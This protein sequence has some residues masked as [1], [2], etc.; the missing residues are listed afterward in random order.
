MVWNMLSEEI[1]ITGYI[2]LPHYICYHMLQVPTDRNLQ[3]MSTGTLR[4]ACSLCCFFPYIP[5]MSNK[6]PMMGPDPIRGATLERERDQSPQ[7]R[8]QLTPARPHPRCAHR[9]R[10]AR[11]GQQC[12][13]A[14][15][16]QPVWP[17]VSWRTTG[18]LQPAQ[19]RWVRAPW[20]LGRLS[21]WQ[22]DTEV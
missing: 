3:T 4:T 14:A 16:C 11:G 20:P 13:S 17:P 1:L 2:S 15:A 8:P 18:T 12:P 10:Q 5:D 9:K 7:P 22:A 21:K 19:C 6:R